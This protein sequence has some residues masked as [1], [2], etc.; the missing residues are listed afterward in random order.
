M[1]AVVAVAALPGTVLVVVPML[2]LWPFEDVVDLASPLLWGGS[3][4][5]PLGL[6]LVAW[7]ITLF[8]SR[9]RGTLAPWD[10][11]SRLVV[12]GP[13]RHVRNPMITG[14]VIA[15]VGEAMLFGSFGLL[16]WA[17]GFFGANALYFR[18]VEEPG[19]E[20]RFGDD[21]VEYRAHVPCWVPQPRPWTRGPTEDPA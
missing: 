17:L 3:A 16:V 6:A 14:V 10:P 7:T 19:L 2:I 11:P 9:G 13:Y 12:A 18:L 1:R 20:R 8:A 21:Y 4:V 5:L 15:L